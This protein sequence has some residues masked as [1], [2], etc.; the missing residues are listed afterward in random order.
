TLNETNTYD[1][2]I[3]SHMLLTGDL[4]GRIV[5]PYYYF[6]STADSAAIHLDLVMMTH[7]WRRYN[8]DNVLAGKIPT[9]RW[10]ESNYLSLTGKLAGMSP[11]TISPDLQ[12]TGILQTADSAKTIINVP[13]DRQGK[14]FTTGLVFF[15]NA[16][17]YFNFNKK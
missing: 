7:G 1:D 17:L 13:V 11:G 16:K 8:W 14:V 12:L 10:Q 6:F 4:R 5:N 3:I 2:N 9:P 15:D